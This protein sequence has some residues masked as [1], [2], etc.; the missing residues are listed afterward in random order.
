MRGQA[1]LRLDR[2]GAEYRWRI[3]GCDGAEEARQRLTEQEENILTA[4]C[5]KGDQKLSGDDLA[6]LSG[7]ELDARFRRA[8]SH[9]R[10]L[11]LLSG[12]PGDLGYQATE[13]GYRHLD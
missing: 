6:K 2:P 12:K 9:L 1:I 7:Y 10:Q 11:G 5:E 8:L 3:R 13:A 4:A